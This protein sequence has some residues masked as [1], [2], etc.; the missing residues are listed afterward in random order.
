MKFLC[1]N[2]DLLEENLKRGTKILIEEYKHSAEHLE[3]F[4]EFQE[5]K[6]LSV[7]RNGNSINI[8]CKELSHYYRGLTQ[9]LCNFDKNIY[10]NIEKVYFDNNGFML[11]CS[12][13]AVFR[14][15]KVKNII[16]TLAKLGLNVLM[17]YTEDT[18]EVFEDPYFGIYRG[19]YTKE[20][21]KEIDSYASIFGIEL[22]PCI[23][24]LAHLHNALKWQGKENIKD[25]A[26]ILDVGKEETYVFIEKL[27]RCVKEAFSTRRVHLG[28]DEAVSLGLG[29]YL[30][31]KGYEKSSVL[32]KK[33]CQ[34][35]M[36][37][38]KKLDLSPIMWSDMYIT[39]NT[40]K[41]YYDV[42]SIENYSSWEKPEKEVGL[43]YWDYYHKDK[44]IY[45]KMLKVHMQITNNVIFAGGSWVWNGISPNY[46]K[47]FECTIS[48]LQSCKEYK[49]KE[50]LC[51]AW[52]DNGAE[53]P[54]DAVLPG[55]AL[56]AYLGFHQSYNSKEFAAEF[57]NCTDGYLEDFF[58]LDKFDSLFLNGESNQD[59][60]NPSKYLL[61][62]DPLTGIFDYHIKESDIDTKKYYRDLELRIKECAAHSDKYSK[63]FLYYEKLADA[64][65]GKAD[66]GV[67]LKDLYEEQDLPVLRKI[68]EDEIPNTI[69]SLKKMK[70]LREELWMYDAKPWGY[71]LMDIKL[72]GVITRLEST[73]R[74]VLNYINGKIAQLEE[75]EDKRMPYFGNKAN[76]RE[77]RWSQII[78]GSD[79]VDT[80]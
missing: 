38:C 28:M 11:D 6:E 1:K 57:K 10:E 36:N 19:R 79:L 3:I 60:D 4:V 33:H 59:A 73:K 77:N 2:A 54:I 9:I 58:I 63:L 37:I 21:I 80:I 52:L 53:T 48:A 32:I 49:L 44:K 46:S 22:V 8:I 43:V 55:V 62:Q 18:Y 76:K 45:D 31:N 66:L 61:Y 40:G 51:T 72:G 78:S 20:E 24:T 65:S 35:V 47:T 15:D 39:S 69:A 42:E 75:L 68:C 50:V 5:N 17:L 14:V 27:L 74:R 67:R 23:Q 13:N 34:R 26:D 64:L 25:T 41:E 70:I 29:N 30:K 71:E 56:F 16:R 12:R 7:K